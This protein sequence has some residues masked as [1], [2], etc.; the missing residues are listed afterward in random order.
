MA[1]YA[2]IRMEKYKKDRLNGTQ[3]H[4]QRE[5]KNTKNENIDRGRSHLNYDLVNDRSISYSKAVHEKIEERV[6]R[7][8]RADA[9][10]VSEFLITASPEYMNSLSEEEQK[11]F[12]EKAFD[13]LKEK[14][15]EE[16]MLY[17]VVH[18]DEATPHMHVGIVPITEDGRLAAKDFFHG[19]AKMK[20]IQDDFH[21]YMTKNGFDLERGEASEKKHENIH[22]YKLNQKK[23]ELERLDT[24]IKLKE[25]R[26]AELVEQNKA[27]ESV[28]SA[29]KESILA[30]PNQFKVPTVTAEKAFLKKD[31]VVVPENELNQLY[32]YAQ[33]MG[34]TN[35]DLVHRLKAETNEKENWKTIAETHKEQAQEKEELLGKMVAQ[36]DT[37]VELSKKQMRKKLIKEFTEEQKETIREEVKEELTFLKAENMALKSDNDDLKRQTAVLSAEKEN[38]VLKHQVTKKSFKKQNNDFRELLTFA[39]KQNDSFEKLKKENVELKEEVSALKHWKDKMVQWAKANLQTLP[40]KAFSFFRAAGMNKEAQKYKGN[41]LEM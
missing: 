34:K 32:Q 22:D 19:K 35:I 7:K 12:F 25:K 36:I 13:H 40:K 4:N 5:F 6:S 3:K 9:V 1:N 18:H 20:A 17:A 37:E 27:I 28:V 21:T 15:T 14:Y 8:V 33:T 2:V 11:R 29:K 39:K 41:E 16:N 31:K 24:E 38:E 30:T 26:N 10:L 23:A